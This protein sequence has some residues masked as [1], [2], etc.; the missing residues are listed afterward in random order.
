MPKWHISGSCPWPLHLHGVTLEKP[1]QHERPAWLFL[2]KQPLDG[3]Q[4][5][6]PGR[7]SGEVS[8]KVECLP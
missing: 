1:L 5:V 8:L 6:K 7:M 2:H 3:S 4:A